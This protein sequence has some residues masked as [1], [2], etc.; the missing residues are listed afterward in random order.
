MYPKFI[1][2]VNGTGSGLMKR[3][4]FLAQQGVGAQRKITSYHS[5]PIPVDSFTLLIQRDT[6]ILFLFRNKGNMFAED[7]KTKM[8]SIQRNDRVLIF[9]IYAHNVD[10]NVLFLSPLEYKIE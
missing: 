4:Q 8:K 1:A 3:G 5:E 7:L 2:Q 10:G 6:S 9:N